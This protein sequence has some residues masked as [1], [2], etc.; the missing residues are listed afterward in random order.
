MPPELVPRN[1]SF[2]SSSSEEES[3]CVAAAAAAITATNK[4][5]EAVVIVTPYSTGCCVAQEIARRGYRLV[6]LWKRGFSEEMKAH[7]PVSC[8]GLSYYAE[9]TEEGTLQD[10]AQAVVEAADGAPIAAVVCGGEAGVDLADALSEEMGLLT[11]GTDV[12]NRRDKKVQQELVGAAGLRS[13]RQAGGHRL[14]DV[15]DFLRTET[16]PVVV[17]PVDSAGSDGVKLCRSYDEARE[18]FVHLTTDHE[19]VNGG[20]CSLALCQEYLQ[21]PEYVVDMVSRDG[22]HKAVMVWRYDKRPANGA[23]F[24][25]F[26]VLPVDSESPEARLLIPYVRGVL[27][28]LGMKNGPS[29]GEVILTPDGPC[30]VE[31]N[32]RYEPRSLTTE[33]QCGV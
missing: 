12:P 13:V 25:Y 2:G 32:C 31:M 5:A 7:V 18:H 27:D 21:G 28:A 30:L 26:G 3:G 1:V 10:T 16:Y 4:A 14:S 33:W 23:A 8:G 19:M 6:C 15:E 29:H 24:V 22:L 17:K 11:N 20:R 9:L